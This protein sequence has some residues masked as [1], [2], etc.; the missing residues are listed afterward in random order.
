[1]FSPFQEPI[2]SG[3][4]ANFEIQGEKIAWSAPET[5][6]YAAAHTMIFE[7]LCEQIQAKAAAAQANVATTTELKIPRPESATKPRA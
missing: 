2:T 1:M 7:L 3:V 4:G 5:I 6:P